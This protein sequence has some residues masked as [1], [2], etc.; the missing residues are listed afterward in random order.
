MLEYKGSLLCWKIWFE[1]SL[2]CQQT[3]IATLT[4]I[5]LSY[6]IA[7]RLCCSVSWEVLNPTPSRTIASAAIGVSKSKTYKLKNINKPNL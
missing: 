7:V 6:T 5:C 2:P 3:V 1:G 4:K